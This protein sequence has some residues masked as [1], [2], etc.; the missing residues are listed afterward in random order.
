M[1]ITEV[2][3]Q[4]ILAIC[5]DPHVSKAVV[6]KGGSAIRLFEKDSHRLSIDAD[7]SLEQKLDVNDKD[8]FFERIRKALSEEFK[9]KRLIVIDFKAT[10]RPAKPKEGFPLSWG[11]WECKFKLVSKDFQHETIEVQRRNAMVPEGSNSPIME[12]DIS[13]GEYCGSKRSKI[14]SGVKIQGYTRE[15]LVLE[16][17]RAICQQHPSYE[18]TSRKGKNRA[19]DFYDIQRLSQQI[20][21]E[22]IR[23]CK[24]HLEKVFS[25]KE[26]PLKLLA[27]LWDEEFIADQGM[28]FQEVVDTVNYTIEPFD[29]YVQY[30]RH[31]VRQIYPEAIEPR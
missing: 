8:V 6:L 12:I 19:R 26:V 23:K 17:I 27:V 31:L 24:Q 10:R 29:V 3:D 9:N 14:I 28:G 21:E 16:K 1:T 25:A 30:V 4:S 5:R 22:F 11:G 13:D 7:F 15:L 2:I 18:F 20:D